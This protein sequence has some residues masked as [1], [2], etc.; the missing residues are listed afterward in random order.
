MPEYSEPL[1]A[2][3]FDL[4]PVLAEAVGSEIAPEDLYF[5]LGSAAAL[6]TAPAD[7][8]HPDRLNYAAI[9]SARLKIAIHRQLL[10]GR[11]YPMARAI[12]Q[13]RLMSTPRL[14]SDPI[15]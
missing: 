3:L 5:L 4:A 7:E 6:I 2:A 10:G 1:N 15:H 14:P 12:Q 9:L 11:G 13:N 8:F